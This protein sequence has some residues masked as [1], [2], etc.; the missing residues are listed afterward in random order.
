M[1][2]HLPLRL[3]FALLAVLALN[4]A[5]GAAALSASG[6]ASATLDPKEYA[7]GLIVTASEAGLVTMNSTS[8][9]VRGASSITMT[10]GGLFTIDNGTFGSGSTATVIVNMS[11]SSVFTMNGGTLA[12]GGAQLTLNINQSLFD[13]KHG[14][15]SNSFASAA[16]HSSATIN[17]NDGGQFI[18]S[19]TSASVGYAGGGATVHVNS[20]GVFTQNGGV[21]SFARGA[22]GGKVEALVHSGGKY[23]LKG[24]AI[25]S[26]NAM[27]RITVEDGGLFEL[28]SQGAIADGTSAYA[29]IVVASGATFNMSGGKI[30]S[31]NTGYAPKAQLI[32]SGSFNQSG[33]DIATADGAAHVIVQ[34]GG[35]Y[36]LS[37][38]AIGRAEGSAAVE[39]RRGG[40][41]LLSGSGSLLGN[42]EV[43]LGY[44]PDFSVSYVGYREDIWG[45][46]VTPG[47]PAATGAQV[48]EQ[49]GGVIGDTVQVKLVGADASFNQSGGD[50]CGSASLSLSEGASFTMSSEAEIFDSVAVTVG[51]G[52]SF[53]MNG[54]SIYGDVSLT[55]DHA[56]FVQSSGSIGGAVHITLIG[57]THTQSG[58]SMTLDDDNTL[59]LS[60]G[61]VFTQEGGSIIG[62][63]IT[64][65]GE[66]TSL[67]SVGGSVTGTD[68]TLAEGT[69]LSLTGSSVSGHIAADAAAVEQSGGQVQADV[70][71]T[72]GSSYTQ[73][74][75]AA[76]LG[77]VSI[78]GSEWVQESGSIAHGSA[79]DVTGGGRFVQKG[80]SVDAA[81]A[82]SEGSFEQSGAVQGDITVQGAKSSYTQKAGNIADGSAV[83]V[84]DGASFTQESSGDIDADISVSS[85]ASLTQGGTLTGKVTA[86]AAKVTQSGSI[87]GDVELSSSSSMV[88]SGSVSGKVVADASTVEQQADGSIGNVELS[89]GA[90]L[91][92]GGSISG[93]VS[94]TDSTV[95]QQASGSIGGDVTL[96]EGASL[97]QTAGGSIGGGVELSSGSSLDQAGSITGSVTATDSTVTQQAGSVIGGSLTADHSTITQA[98]AEIR[99]DVSLSNGSSLTQNGGSITGNV[100]VDAST[101]V[102]EGGSI[103]GNVELTNGA[104]M[105]QD[106]SIGGD[107]SVASGASFTRK[108]GELSGNITVDAAEVSLGDTNVGGKVT[109]RNKGVYSQGDGDIGGAVEVSGS[110]FT[111]GEGNI[112]GGVIAVDSTLMLGSGDINSGVQLSG[113]SFSG[114]EGT[115]HGNVELVSGSSFEVGI[116]KIEGNVDISDSTFKVGGGSISGDVSAR[117]GSVFE[118]LLTSI[119]GHVQVIDSEFTG[120][121]IGGGV[122]VTNGSFTQL[123]AGVIHK[124]VRVVSSTFEQNGEIE[125]GNVYVSEKSHYTMES[126][127]K[128]SGSVSVN[129][130]EFEQAGVITGD[131]TLSS[132]AVYMMKADASIQ[133]ATR[134]KDSSILT[135]EGGSLENGVTVIDSEL[136]QIGGMLRGDISLENSALIHSGGSISATVTMQ[137]EKSCYNMGEGEIGGSVLLH[138]GNLESASKFSGSVAVDTDASYNKAIDLGGVGAAQISSI[139]T[140]STSA[141]ISNVGSGTLKFTGTDNTMLV[142]T[143]TSSSTT[144]GKQYL[145]C[146]ADGGSIAFDDDA[147]ITLN[148][149][150]DVLIE[151]KKANNHAVTIWFT[152]GSLAKTGTETEWL[153]KHFVVGNGLLEP[154]TDGEYGWQ[155][156][157]GGKLTLHINMDG[158]WIASA[159]GVEITSDKWESF[160][161]NKMVIVDKDLTVHHQGGEVTINQLMSSGSDLVNL[162]IEA[163]AASSKVTLMN[164][165]AIAGDT[166]FNGNIIIT[167]TEAGSSELHKQGTGTLTVGGNITG[168][169]V[170]DIE[171]GAL[172]LLGEGSQVGKLAMGENATLTLNGSLALSGESELTGG[173]I[174]GTGELIQNGGKLTLG[175]GVTFGV[176][177]TLGEAAEVERAGSLGGNVT[178]SGAGARLT[179]IGKAGISGNVLMSGDNTT[180]EHQ[181]DGDIGGS[182]ALTGA[183]SAFTQGAGSI[184]GGVTQ[185]GA[186]SKYKHGNGDIQGSIE[187]TG[188]G[189]TFE[190]GAGNITGDVRVDGEGASLKHGKGEISGSVFMGGAGSEFDT[191]FTAIQGSV[192]I[193]GGAAQFTQTGDIIGSVE[194]SGAGAVFDGE[195]GNIKSDVTLSGEAS[196]FTQGGEIA[197]NVTLSG[198]NATFTG[199][200]EDIAGSVEVSGA[201][202]ALNGQDTY[203]KGDVILSG[204]GAALSGSRI[205]GHATL[206]GTGATLAQAGMIKGAVT[207]SGD[208]TKLTGDGTGLN[209]LT[210]TGKRA[211]VTAAGEISGNVLLDGASASVEGAHAVHGDITLA[212][213]GTR[214]AG[215][216]AVDGRVTL[217]GAESQYAAGGIGGDL[218]LT[219]VD[220]RAE[221]KGDVQ[222]SAGVEGDG[223]ELHISGSVLGGV[224]ISGVGAAYEQG[225]G[226][227]S[228]DV[229]VSGADATFSHAGTVDGNITVS[230]A[231]V[232]YEQ[233]GKALGSISITADNVRYTISAGG[234]AKDVLLSGAGSV[235]DLSGADSVSGSI[236]LQAGELVNAGA[237]AGAG[238]VINTTEAQQGA[239]KLGGLKADTITG[240]TTGAGHLLTGLASGSVLSLSGANS[241]YVNMS[242][243]TYSHNEA[244]E[245]MIQFDGN[246][247][248]TFAD[249]GLL[250]LRFAP[251]LVNDFGSG[252]LEVWLTNGSITGMPEDDAAALA[253]L[254]EHVLLAT[255]SGLE[256]A[257][258]HGELSGVHEGWLTI[259]AS[260][261][262]IWQTTEQEAF[263]TD[264]GVFASF[265]KVVIDQDTT[266][267]VESAE[268]TRAVL[269][270]LEGNSKFDIENKGTGELTVELNNKNVLGYYGETEFNGDIT[271]AGNVSIEKNGDADLT[272]N[273]EL[274]TPG[275]VSVREGKL[276][277]NAAANSIATLSLGEVMDDGSI[278]PGALEVNGVLT[279]TG[280]SDLS[281]AHGSISGAG[282]LSLEGSLT[283]GQGVSLS[284]L[285]IGIEEG[286]ELNLNG[287]QGSVISGLSGSGVLNLGQEGSLTLVGA[288]AFSGSLQGSGALSVSGK[289]SALALIG[290]GSANY[291][292]VVG[293]NTSVVLSKDETPFGARMAPD[294]SI[295]WRSITNSGALTVVSLDGQTALT[296]TGDIRLAAGSLTE[297]TVN[298]NSADSA[299]LVST[300][301]HVIIED[302]SSISLNLAG[303]LSGNDLSVT[304]I[305]AAE[306]ICDGEGKQFSEGAEL[307]NVTFNEAIF[308][309]LYDDV[310]V[311]VDST[312]SAVLQATAHEEN[313]LE[314]SGNSR[315]SGAGAALIWSAL[316]QSNPDKAPT[317]YAV[318][319]AVAEMI[320]SGNS[321]GASRTLAAAAGSTVTALGS[322]QQDALR[323]QLARVRDRASVASAAVL[324]PTDAKHRLHAFVETVSSYADLNTDGDEAGYKLSAWGGSVG[325][326]W[327]MKDTVRVG[328]SL[329]AL[330]GDLDS[331]AADT[332]SGSLDTY[333]LSAYMRAKSNKWTHTAVIT[334]ADSSADLSRSVNY[335]TGSYTSSGSTNGFGFGALYEVS[336]DY[337]LNEDKTSILRP[338]LSASV[339]TTSMKGYTEHGA[340]GMSLQ[341]GEQKRTIATLSAGVSWVN[342]VNSTALNR[343]IATEFRLAVAQDMGDTAGKANVALMANPGFSRPV[344][345]SEVGT[346]ALQIGVGIT[347][348]LS[349]DMTMYL[350]GHTEMRDGYINWGAN[351]GLRRAF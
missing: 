340:D 275:K 97:T 220:T 102:Q 325:V 36:A 66:G 181:E 261:S 64:L 141:V 196:R 147:S 322:A 297:I 49:T 286:G 280:D 132:G 253:W 182:V 270:Q 177:L 313:E 161:N 110:S 303:D 183:G 332:A 30:A 293:A 4:P 296:A 268:N 75:N 72:N 342:L 210:L 298:L 320:L 58:G 144:D 239:L 63:E 339:V 16:A 151:A 178:L 201:G 153:T 33:G 218:L 248:V 255:G 188:A 319:N 171:K 314:L 246:G 130:S 328:V 236:T 203:I 186:N 137:G 282:A 205:D 200:Q 47:E 91:T 124:D 208:D 341:V 92:Q 292:L 259:T 24:G 170:L 276:I 142:G 149:S 50:I 135:V 69:S 77:E 180:F 231:G 300:G 17:V 59:A 211:R 104:E 80:G 42:V 165:E 55:F 334:L 138:G 257:L 121:D 95:T 265:S 307:V 324:Q 70:S 94:A 93:S 123:G 60:E 173:S 241:M 54:G 1:K 111:H 233:S 225:S 174:V 166:V 128:I 187:I 56:S 204:A 8:T 318:G 129:A 262:D 2:L 133:G 326:D 312:G 122:E 98:A 76:V 288:G 10:D 107:V 179:Q 184:G 146:F 172:V 209:A 21:V 53:A 192:E 216:A 162:T 351:I 43:A 39:V 9:I 84:S 337:A 5:R 185:S 148:F 283:L 176:N 85:G 157:D 120:G 247:A 154:G 145:I 126:G 327:D 278:T 291:D 229:L 310:A 347:A 198:K 237:Y 46:L 101:L 279:L 27:A 235:L 6:G 13:L 112:A 232:S 3:L 294:H 238:V 90:S 240:V 158:I 290:S 197:G 343:T 304:V 202:A 228:G 140:R 284:G 67:K 45:A 41:F 164:A 251:E 15:V 14:T 281:R 62:G 230:G 350:N 329:T 12:S 81:I 61:A 219:G 28:G 52:S 125:D 68:I 346:T 335:G 163:S 289:G 96:A 156:A 306:G 311:V 116:M 78:E 305:R 308:E 277:L 159:D 194:V 213:D 344:Y 131:L 234:A 86:D 256:F 167:G 272:L 127:A 57:G 266:L 223:A 264:P 258:H 35:R 207:L 323:D 244:S 7:D 139:A 333:Y 227:I 79:I 217:A 29:D 83:S 195:E 74:D 245:A 82:V 37:G 155:S 152:N 143:Q 263:V 215:D 301:G 331:S 336:Y 212:G 115:I 26:N 317:L 214:F 11:G 274:K 38:G 19:S 109:V 243:A 250:K 269:H 221:V 345:G 191:E 99:G 295:A 190:H 18:M 189:S 23:S 252:T 25:A 169:G 118:L 175:E 105:T 316:K 119:A 330:Y 273:G 271:A 44:T 338:L 242:N 267:A 260:S 193:T 20:G 222:G 309:L 48:F 302:G 40:S 349:E 160:K 71:L 134:V 31:S 114:K 299:A 51:S 224:S 87:S 150:A 89:N 73:K 348:P 199:D 254:K 100:A 168:A 315:N 88:Q 226:G 103:G 285:S 113:S 32:V 206:S 287:V 321:A 249:G 108:S 117:D 106:G 34:E 65:E 22:E 136:Q